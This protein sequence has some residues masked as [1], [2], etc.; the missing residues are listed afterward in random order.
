MHL[1]KRPDGSIR[2]SRL[3]PWE[4]QTFRS[5]PDLADFSA[6]PAAEKRLL[7]SPAVE[8]DLSPE[9]AMDW[10]EYVVP[11]LRESFAHNLETVMADLDRLVPEPEPGDLPPA[12]ESGDAIVAETGSEDPDAAEAA[13][14]KERAGDRPPDSPET[15]DGGPAAGNLLFFTLTIPPDHVEHWF[16]A[17]NQARLVLSARYGIDS[18]H[19]P[20]LAQLLENGQLE[21][22][23]QYELFVSLQGW[24]VEAVLDPD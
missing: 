11:E 21:H 3:N 18:E 17:M 19:V 14:R 7:P 13:S 24:L 4:V 1:L 2:L 16:L 23:F 5:L 15:K 12:E 8:A 20:D 6:A 9:I 22:W 10:V